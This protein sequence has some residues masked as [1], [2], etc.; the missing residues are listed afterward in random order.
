MLKHI[1]SKVGT[2]IQEKFQN[3]ILKI[4]NE[5]GRTFR[6]MMERVLIKRTALFEAQQN[7][8]K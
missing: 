5:F 7:E 1:K 2:Y 4:E 6:K 8:E 3:S